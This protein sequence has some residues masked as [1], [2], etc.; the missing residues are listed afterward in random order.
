MV[1]LILLLLYFTN[2]QDRK[3]MLTNFKSDALLLTRFS[4]CAKMRLLVN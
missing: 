3:Q 2:Y 1:Y 4:I